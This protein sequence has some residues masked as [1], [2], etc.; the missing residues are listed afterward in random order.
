MPQQDLV[1]LRGTSFQKH[2]ITVYRHFTLFQ[3]NTAHLAHHTTHLFA[4]HAIRRFEVVVPLE[5]LGNVF[6]HNLLNRCKYSFYEWHVFSESD[7]EV[8]CVIEFKFLWIV[9][10][11]FRDQ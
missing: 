4:D 2:L 10:I 5:V 7:R 1:A 3:L 9:S 6:E 8:I 11:W